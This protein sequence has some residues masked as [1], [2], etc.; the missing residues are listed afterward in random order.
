MGQ[1]RP[2][3]RFW[4]RV[5]PGA[6]SGPRPSAQ[7]FGYKYPVSDCGRSGLTAV[8]QLELELRPMSMRTVGLALALAAVLAL[9]VRAE[10]L[11]VAPGPGPAVPDAASAAR[12]DWIALSR[13]LAGAWPGMQLPSG[14]VS[15]HLR[16]GDPGT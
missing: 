6:T 11:A 10:D 5:A 1:I 15:D 2:S 16:E 14:G 9:G 12:G 8:A 7:P 13:R 4:E 3:F